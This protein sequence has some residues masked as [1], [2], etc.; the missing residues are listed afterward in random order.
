MAPV[1]SSESQLNSDSAAFLPSPLAEC[2]NYDGVEFP[3]L[4]SPPEG[5]SELSIDPSA[6]CLSLREHREHLLNLLKRHSV[7]YFRGFAADNATAKDFAAYVTEGFGLTPFPYKLGNAVRRQIVGDVVFTANEAPPERVIPFHHELAQTPSYP[8]CLLFFC[9]VP[10]G[11]GGATPVAF[12]PAVLNALRSDAPRLVDTLQKHGVV[13]SRT[14]TRHDRPESAI[15][16]GWAS[17]FGA[18]SRSDV[19]T[20]L[21]SRG[22]SWHWH[23]GAEDA[24]LTEISPVLPAIIDYEGR[25]SFFNQIYAAW[26]GWR[27]EFNNPSECIRAGNG[28]KF[29]SADMEA[30]ERIMKEHEVAVPWQRGDFMIIDNMQAMHSRHTFTGK[31]VVL[32]SL[33]K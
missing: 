24:V 21:H 30:L 17:T 25:S 10:A 31:R 15:G 8:S 4:L 19:E 26:T 9:D 12:S 5:R 16:R 29:D 22:Y 1:A 27:D 2:R 33:T 14:M 28:D 32:A 23:G 11:T 20:I 18:T 3:L 13:Y 7:L 6:V